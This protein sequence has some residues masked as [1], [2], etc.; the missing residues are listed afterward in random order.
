MLALWCILIGVGLAAT[1]LLLFRRPVKKVPHEARLAQARNRFH[2]QREW[3]EAKFIRL[4]AAQAPPE[5]PRWA[6]CDFEDG[7]SYVRHRTTGELSAF[8]AVTVALE[9][10]SQPAASGGDLIGNFRAGTAVFRF[11]KDHWETEGRVIL[12]LTPREAIRFYQS[13]FEIVGQELVADD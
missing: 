4:A 3:L 8:V 10:V 2:R 11:D 12:N 9:G 13:D 1:G 6:D 5:A 7:V